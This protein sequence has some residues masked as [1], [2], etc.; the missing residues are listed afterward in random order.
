MKI[1][2]DEEILFRSMP[3]AAKLIKE[4]GLDINKISGTGK[5][6]RVTKGDVLLYLKGNNPSEKKELNKQDNKISIDRKETT[7]DII[8]PTLGESIV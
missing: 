5:G 7:M 3:S 1:S 8:V 2:V 6:G 4:K